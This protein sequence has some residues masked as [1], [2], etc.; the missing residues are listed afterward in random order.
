MVDKLMKASSVNMVFGSYS[1]A[2][3]ELFVKRDT[4]TTTVI[5]R[6][7]GNTQANTAKY[8]EDSS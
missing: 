7:T 4:T 8:Y 1:S 3:D 5:P 6:T 2:S